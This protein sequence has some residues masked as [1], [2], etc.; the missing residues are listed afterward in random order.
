MDIYL[1]IYIYILFE[2]LLNCM[3]DVFWKHI[4]LLRGKFK[5]IFLRHLLHELNRLILIHYKDSRL[6]LAK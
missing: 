5:N 4:T 3:F 1:N 2:C 6:L